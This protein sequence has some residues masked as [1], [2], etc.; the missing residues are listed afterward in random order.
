M[1]G[2][3]K[4]KEEN[5]QLAAVL[6]DKILAQSREPD[7]YQYF[8][9][10]DT[11]QGRFD[12]LCVHAFLIVDRLYED[13]PKGT[14]LAQSFFDHM[15]KETDKNLRELGIGDLSVP[16]HI[17]KLMRGFKGRSMAY[18]DAMESDE[19]YDLIEALM[20]NLY[21]TSEKPDE[22]NACLIASY[23]HE[24]AFILGTTSEEDFIQ[25]DF[26]FP[27]MPKKDE[28][29]QSNKTDDPRMVA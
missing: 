5:A 9:V 2:F 15:F 24:T 14:K 29:V 23:M 28:E 22:K 7:F 6:Y 11:I 21:G 1:F 20:R 26:N 19:H 10:P 18:R 8:G 25:A 16:K 3:F 27:A 17:K 12:L 13:G 4:K